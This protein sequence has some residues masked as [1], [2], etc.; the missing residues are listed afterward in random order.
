MKRSNIM[1]V[2]A[3]FIGIILAVSTSAFKPVTNQDTDVWGKDA[4]GMYINIT[5]QGLIENRD[6]TCESSSDACKLEYPVGQN[7]NVN[8]SG[9]VQVGSNGVFVLTP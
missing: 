2:S 6:Y 1:S 7:P 8:P 4:S 9:G 5:Q 3:L